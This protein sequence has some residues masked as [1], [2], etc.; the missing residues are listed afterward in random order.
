MQIELTERETSFILSLRAY[1]LARR[2]AA[3]SKE[4]G[5]AV[6]PNYFANPQDSVCEVINCRL[7][8]N[9]FNAQDFCDVGSSESGNRAFDCNGCHLSLSWHR[10]QSGN[11]E[12]VAYIS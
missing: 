3:A 6:A 8:A 12:I 10:M 1:T 7:I 4:V 11:F 9:G 2:K 5:L